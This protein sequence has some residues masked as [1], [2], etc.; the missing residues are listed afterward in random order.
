M[1]KESMDGL[2]AAM[3]GVFREPEQLKMVLQL[4]ANQ[5]MNQEV[6]NYLG[7][8]PHERSPQRIG[9]RN[10]FKPRGLRTRVGE[11]ELQ[12]PQVRGC[13]P[14]HPSLFARFERSERALLVACGEMYF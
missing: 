13:E 7:A 14:Y 10:G 4:L 11:L 12:V 8:E 1:A 5:A 9:Q 3:Q 6:S 2:L